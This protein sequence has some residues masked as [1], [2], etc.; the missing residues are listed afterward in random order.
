MSKKP[1]KDMSVDERVEANI[2]ELD[3]AELK[4]HEYLSRRD[5][6]GLEGRV[7]PSQ[8]LR[9]MV[10]RGDITGVPEDNIQPSSFEPVVAEDTGVIWIASDQGNSFHPRG[11]ATIDEA[12]SEGD[13]DH[14]VYPIG[15]FR[16]DV[17]NLYAIPMQGGI[18]LKPTQGVRSSNKSGS[19]RSWIRGKTMIDHFRGFDDFTT[20]STDARHYGK[21]NRIWALASPLAWNYVG[22]PGS[23]LTQLRVT[24]GLDFR[25]TDGEI[26]HI[27]DECG[28]SFVRNDK[29]EPVEPVLDDGIVLHLD[30]AGDLTQGIPAYKARNFPDELDLDHRKTTDPRPY[31]EP[32]T[33]ERGELLAQ[34]GDKILA[35]FQEIVHMHPSTCGDL[36]PYNTVSIDSPSNFARF[37]NNGDLTKL[38]LEIQITGDKPVRLYHGM[39]MAKMNIMYT[40]MT[41]KPYSAERNKHAGQRR[42]VLAPQFEDHDLEAVRVYGWR[43]SAKED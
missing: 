29:M 26:R 14:K 30:L 1:W 35:C 11:R 24:E 43:G 31:H 36:P 18:R 19:A 34:P 21:R 8:D 15:R 20:A 27:Y 3:E 6:R 7:L 28:F 25:L 22:R 10:K 13:V 42:V 2:A 32:L 5:E 41:D 38:V 12:I 33:A 9:E 40:G 39:P 4:T 37:V 16:M 23:R 17:H